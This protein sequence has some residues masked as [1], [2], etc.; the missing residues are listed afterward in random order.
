VE[1]AMA[2]GMTADKLHDKRGFPV[3]ASM[4]EILQQAANGKKKFFM[5]DGTT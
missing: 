2:A 1:D 5:T 3:K 4:P